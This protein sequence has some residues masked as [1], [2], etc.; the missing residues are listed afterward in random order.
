[1][2]LDFIYTQPV[3]IV[4]GEGKFAQLGEVLQELGVQR[5]VIACGRHLAEPAA[6]RREGDRPHCP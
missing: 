6:F 1:M 5:C 3:K 2:A 4:F